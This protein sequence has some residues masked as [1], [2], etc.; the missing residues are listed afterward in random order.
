[1]NS[2]FISASGCD[3]NDGLTPQTPWK[4]ISKANSVVQCGDTVCIKCGDVFFGQIRAPKGNTTSMP[5]TVIYVTIPK[6]IG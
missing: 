2:Y 6:I 3:F 4:T 1:M 5:T